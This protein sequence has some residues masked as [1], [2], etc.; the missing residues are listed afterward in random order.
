MLPQVKNRDEWRSALESGGY[1]CQCKSL[2]WSSQKNETASNSKT[3][4]RLVF[5]SFFRVFDFL[6]CSVGFLALASFFPLTCILNNG[7]SSML[8]VVLGITF[9]HV[10]FF[11][12][13][14]AKTESYSDY[15]SYFCVCPHQHHHHTCDRR[16]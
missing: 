16:T 13:S 6:C 12:N 9:E 8:S 15:F 1:D 3:I 11:S 7:V 10:Y 14:D 2:N 5:V 4:K